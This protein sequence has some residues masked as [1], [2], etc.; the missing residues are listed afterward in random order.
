MGQQAANQLTSGDRADATG[1]HDRLV[2]APGHLAAVLVGLRGGLEGAEVAQQ[3]RPAELVVESYG[4]YREYKACDRTSLR[5]CIYG[6][7]DKIIE[8]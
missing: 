5:A 7:I 8:L 2:I 4:S 3:V 6:K 1:D